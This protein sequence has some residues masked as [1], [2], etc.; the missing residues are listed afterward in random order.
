MITEILTLLAP[1]AIIQGFLIAWFICN[2][3]PAQNLFN[4]KL[5]PTL[6]KKKMGYLAKLLSCHICASFWT[7]LIIS[8]NPFAAIAASFL[9]YTYAKII[10]SFRTFV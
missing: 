1:V 7:T 9:A 3:E 4:K 5:V 2:F 10:N 8:F 6:Q